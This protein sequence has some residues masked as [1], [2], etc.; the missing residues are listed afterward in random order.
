M[1]QV[2]PQLSLSIDKIIPLA[3][4]STHTAP[5]GAAG[6]GGDLQEAL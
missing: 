1:E 4:H 5:V 2:M 6:V 3:V